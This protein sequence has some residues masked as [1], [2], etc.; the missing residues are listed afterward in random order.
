M[1]AAI[2]VTRHGLW[3]L[4]AICRQ[5]A[6]RMAAERRVDG[7]FDFGNAERLAGA[8]VERLRGYAQSRAVG[9]PN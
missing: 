7:R 4:R 8:L 2:V 1:Q 3:Q 9:Q 5:F 6:A